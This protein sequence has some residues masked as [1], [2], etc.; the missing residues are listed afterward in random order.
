M[1][2]G[3]VTLEVMKNRWERGTC[4]VLQDADG[5]KDHLMTRNIKTS[6]DCTAGSGKTESGLQDIRCSSKIPKLEQNPTPSG[7]QPRL[8]F[9]KNQADPGVT[10]IGKLQ[11]WDIAKSLA[12]AGVTS[13]Q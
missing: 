5:A 8:H 10:E 9:L 13:A 11:D 3:M 12:H 4:L 7:L 6:P 1:P 2:P